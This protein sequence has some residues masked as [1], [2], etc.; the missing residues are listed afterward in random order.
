M[1]LQPCPRG[2]LSIVYG[3]WEASQSSFVSP[4][5]QLLCADIP[6]YVHWLLL[7]F[8]SAVCSIILIRSFGLKRPCMNLAIV[9]S[10]RYFSVFPRGLKVNSFDA[11]F[12]CSLMLQLSIL[13]S[14]RLYLRTSERLFT[15]PILHTILA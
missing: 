14:R 1:L 11:A 3:I 2:L 10:R 13:S 4:C 6:P 15:R 5:L 9:S 8:V 7:T 12:S